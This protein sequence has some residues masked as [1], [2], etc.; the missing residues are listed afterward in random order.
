V[1]ENYRHGCYLA[2]IRPFANFSIW[3][4]YWK[5]FANGVWIGDLPEE[6]KNFRGN[7][8]DWGEVPSGSF[9]FSTQTKAR[10]EESARG[11]V[12]LLLADLARRED[13]HPE[14]HP[15]T[16][17]RKDKSMAHRA[18]HSP[19]TARKGGTHGQVTRRSVKCLN[20]PQEG[21]ANRPY[22]A[23]KIF[24]HGSHNPGGEEFS[25]I[26]RD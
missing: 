13:R 10:D 14:M 24:R 5:A 22:F 16:S 19:T 4:V 17:T 21:P 12:A 9:R 26:Y 11:D 1:V 25:R 3:F 7:P 8:I 2:A 6:S 20:R 23:Y 15:Q 18:T